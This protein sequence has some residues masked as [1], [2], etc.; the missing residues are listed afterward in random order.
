MPTV[1]SY[2]I[3]VI[4]KGG[5]NRYCTSDMSE[6]FSIINRELDKEVLIFRTYKSSN[7]SIIRSERLSWVAKKQGFIIKTIKEKPYVR[8]EE[9]ARP[10]FYIPPPKKISESSD[11]V[12]Q[13]SNKLYPALRIKPRGA[14]TPRAQTSLG[15]EAV[16]APS[17]IRE[18]VF[19]RGEKPPVKPLVSRE[20][21]P[22][23][24]VRLA[25][26]RQ[27]AAVYHA[28][29]KRDEAKREPRRA[30]KNNTG[31]ARRIHQAVPGRRSPKLGVRR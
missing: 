25:R 4:G 11:I 12:E 14:V 13:I 21:F 9:A 30:G 28:I 7:G 8:K 6:L 2:E 27:R 22:N 10:N 26:V 16:R 1:V 18:G 5:I 23:K 29:R 15:G 17:V 3:R 19:Y 31:G 24:A 20:P